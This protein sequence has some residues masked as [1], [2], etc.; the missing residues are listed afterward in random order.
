MSFGR[1]KDVIIFPMIH[2]NTL[3][4]RLYNFPS[5]FL[6][7]LFYD[8]YLF[9]RWHVMYRD[10][11]NTVRRAYIPTNVLNYLVYVKYNVVVMYIVARV[12]GVLY[13]R[14]VYWRMLYDRL[15]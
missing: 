2:I 7:G 1:E 9:V 15:E 10:E 4:F 5:A 12:S 6:C 13:V 11:F 8:C 14:T 3:P